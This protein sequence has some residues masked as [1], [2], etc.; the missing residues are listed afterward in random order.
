MVARELGMRKQSRAIAA[1]V[2]IAME[3]FAI[4][5]RRHLV[6]AFHRHR[7]AA[8]GND[9]GSG[10]SR[11]FSGVARFAA[12]HSKG[13]GTKFPGDT[14]FDRVIRYSRELFDDEQPRRAIELLRLAIEEDQSQRALWLALIELCFLI[15]DETRLTEL[16]MA[17]ATEFALDSELPTLGAMRRELMPPDAAMNPAMTNAPKLLEPPNWSMP[18][19]SAKNEALQK[20][21]HAR[22]QHATITRVN[23]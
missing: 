6:K 2:P 11:Y 16:I 17:F 23:Q 14:R 15:R 19:D 12:A 9:G 3:Q 8:N 21:F 10:Y 1:H 20:Q 18:A 7:F 22:L 5:L 4:V 13:L